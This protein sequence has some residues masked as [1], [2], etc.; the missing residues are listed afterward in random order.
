MAP[1]IALQTIAGRS[2]AIP[3]PS[4]RFVH[5]QFRRFAGCPVCNFHLMTLARRQPEIE[6][7]GIHQVVL[8][9]SSK[10][11]MRKYQA[12]LPFDCVADLGKKH[13]RQFG[14]E[15]SVLA[16]LNPRVFWSGMRWVLASRRFYRKAEN[17]IT[18]LPAD[19]LIDSGGRVVA[20]NYGTHADD[21]WDADELLKLAADAGHVTPKPWRASALPNAE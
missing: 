5:L 1:A 17:G 6:A 12:Q 9:H 10:E 21:Q 13:Y 19:F 11:E 15:N 8:F 18:G 14:V 4:A 20:C 2:I 7:A 16:L 3:N